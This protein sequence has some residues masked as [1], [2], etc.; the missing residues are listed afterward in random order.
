M[1]IRL[2]V[3]LAR[4]RHTWFV[5][6]RKEQ[7]ERSRALFVDTALRLFVDQGYEATPI[8]QILEEADMAKGALYHHFPDGKKQLFVEVVDVVDHQLHEGFDHILETIT[9]PVEQIAAGFDLLL[10]L[11]SD[12]EFARIILIEAAAVMPGAWTAGSE[13]LLL[14]NTLRRA[15]E[16]G[17]IRTMPLDAATSTLYG[18]ARRAADFVAQASEPAEAANDCSAVLHALL[19]GLRTG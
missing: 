12:R 17:E 2:S 1:N 14:Q 19:N 9:S 11:A 3:R 16:A 18:A 13:F 10:H 6:S 5:S 4:V 7:A 8:S 15:M